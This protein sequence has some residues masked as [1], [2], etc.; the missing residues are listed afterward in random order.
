M[1]EGVVT[2]EALNQHKDSPLLAW[3]SDEA[4]GRCPMLWRLTTRMPWNV[5]WPS[6]TH[7]VIDL[8]GLQDQDAETPLGRLMSWLHQQC[9]FDID[10]TPA[11][12]R[13][14]S[15]QNDAPGEESTDFWDRL[16][17]EELSYDPRT[18]NYPGMTSGLK[19]IGHDLFSVNWRS[20]SQWRH[21]TTRCCV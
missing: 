13:T 2:A 11:A 21:G 9:I 14:Q 19:P 12:R 7:R 8:D 20:C 5:A 3:L 6:A 4:G 18:A 17:A 10:D 15:A 1:L 16:L